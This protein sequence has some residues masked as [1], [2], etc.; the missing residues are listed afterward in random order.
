MKIRQYA[1]YVAPDGYIRKTELK[2]ADG[3]KFV[4]DKGIT[5][6]LAKLR[7]YIIDDEQ[8]EVIPNYLTASR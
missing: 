8:T 2:E 3:K 5:I 7:F 4:V 1:T 6:P